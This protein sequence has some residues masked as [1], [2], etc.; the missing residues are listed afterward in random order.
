M[1]R[2]GSRLENIL[3]NTAVQNFPGKENR[4]E[5]KQQTTQSHAAPTG[6]ISFL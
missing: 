1:S 5:S 2:S 4:A 3:Q 6:P